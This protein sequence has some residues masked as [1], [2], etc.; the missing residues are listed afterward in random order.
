MNKL[1]SSN[2]FS[3]MWKKS[4]EDCGK[5]QEFMAKSLGVSRKTVQNWED[6]LSSPNHQKGLEWFAVLG[7]SPM[8]YY[9]RALYPQPSDN[10]SREKYVE[11]TLFSIIKDLP[12]ETKEKL[13]YLLAGKH[14][15][16][17]I[18]MMELTTA[19]L[20]CPLRDRLNVAHN[21]AINY[22]LAKIEGKVISNDD[23]QP[24]MP[25]LYDAIDKGMDSV[26]HGK[27]G[28]IGSQL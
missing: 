1:E 27:S 2:V 13:L 12:C 8:H 28:Y 7:L 9:I 10:I 20:Q 14:G 11:E 23:I 5:S 25:L 15:S 22:E 17:P 26:R 19:H 4:R 3:E 21:V 16:S 6:G 24:N 18:C